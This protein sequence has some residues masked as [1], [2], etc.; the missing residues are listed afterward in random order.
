MRKFFIIL[1]FFFIGCGSLSSYKEPSFKVIESKENISIREY[2]SYLIAYTEEKGT[3]DS[4]ANPSF[5]K[6]FKYIQGENI[7]KTT[8]PMTTPVIEKESQ[9]IPMTVPVFE[10]ET[11]NFYRMEFVLPETMNLE[12]APKPTNPNVKLEEIKS[13]LVAVV[14]F[15]GFMGK[16]KIESKKKELSEYLKE[17]NYKPVGEFYQARYNAPFTIP[18]LRRN[19]VLIEVKK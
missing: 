15:S 11:A 13:K 6:L 10:K 1:I 8:I 14:V 12:N 4:N 19:E 16:E 7:S 18:F 3:S 5:R 17:N 2:G 9:K